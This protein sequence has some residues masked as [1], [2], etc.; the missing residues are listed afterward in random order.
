MWKAGNLTEIFSV[1]SFTLFVHYMLI[2]PVQRI[3]I[4]NLRLDSWLNKKPVTERANCEAGS[5]LMK[6]KWFTLSD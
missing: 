1:L 2:Q 5:R 4:Y 6:N 3:D